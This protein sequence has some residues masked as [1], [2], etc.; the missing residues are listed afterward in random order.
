MKLFLAAIATLV[1]VSS[2]T[3]L[4][5]Q[6]TSRVRPT[7]FV[8]SRQGSHPDGP[9]TI[10]HASVFQGDILMCMLVE[11]YDNTHKA[12]TACVVKFKDGARHTLN[13]GESMQLPDDDEFSLECRGRVPR[14]CMIEVNPPPVKFVAQT[15]VSK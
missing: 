8:E 12:R 6:N 7:S 4:V 9:D 11:V 15:P 10:A 3:F 13:H 1:A 5:C 14:R 2:T